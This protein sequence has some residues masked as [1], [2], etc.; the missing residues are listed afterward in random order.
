MQVSK[1]LLE[2]LKMGYFIRDP[3]DILMKMLVI[4]LLMNDQV[5]RK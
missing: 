1:Q 4:T 5:K 3:K 2:I